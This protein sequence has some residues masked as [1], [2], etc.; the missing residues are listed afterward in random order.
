MTFN[1]SFV[2]EPLQGARLTEEKAGVG[3]P[4]VIIYLI[5]STHNIY[6]HVPVML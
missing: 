6:G 5:W 1:Q 3:V 4:L 2:F